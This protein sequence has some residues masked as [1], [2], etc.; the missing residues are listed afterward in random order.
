VAASFGAGSGERFEALK[1]MGLRQRPNGGLKAAWEAA[2][3]AALKRHGLSA[4]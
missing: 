1:A 2:A 3:G 4:G